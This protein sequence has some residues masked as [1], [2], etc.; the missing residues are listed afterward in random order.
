MAPS[1]GL[2]MT[3]S[4]AA[5]LVHHVVLPPKLP[6]EDDYNASHEHCLIDV[7]ICALQDVR[8]DVKGQDL[9]DLVT[10]AITA[11]MNLDDSRDKNGDVSELQVLTTLGKLAHATTDQILPLE[12]KAQNAGILASR[13]GDRVVFETFEL[14][15]TNKAAMGPTGRLIRSF[16]GSA[17]EIPVSVAKE[18][19]FRVSYAYTI[20]KMSTQN[21]REFRAQVRKNGKEVEEDRDTNDPAMVSEWLVN[22]LASM[23]CL[24][25]PVRIT[26]NMRE[27]VLWKDCRS[28]W[29]RSPLW[30]LI[31]VTLQLL[32]TRQG[33]TVRPLGGLYKAFVVQ[34]LSRILQSTKEHWKVL[35]SEILYVAYA[36][37]ARR[38]RKLE[39]L[40]QLDLLESR[41]AGHLQA[42]IVDAHNHIDEHWTSLAKRSDMNANTSSLHNL[43]PS[44]DLDLLLPELDAFLTGV[45]MRRRDR[46]LADF[47]PDGEYAAFPQDELPSNLRTSGQPNHL[48]LAALELWIEQHLELWLSV[49]LHENKTCGNIYALMQRYHS[50]ASTE[51]EGKPT[52]LSLMYLSLL[53]LWVASDSSACYIFPLLCQFDPELSSGELQCLVLPFRSQMQRLSNV[54]HY[55]QARRDQATKAN[56]SVLQQFGLASTFAVKYFDQS[57]ELQATL[58]EIKR[59]AAFKQKQKLEELANLKRRHKDLMDHYNSNTCQT[60]RVLVNRYH[61]YYEDKHSTS[62]TRCASKTAADDLDIMIYEWPLSSDEST[63][64][65]TV[66][67]LCIPQAFSDWRDASMYLI[68][69]VLGYATTNPTKPLVKYTLGQH[70]GLTHF[71]SS[72]YHGRRIVPLSSVKSHTS[73]HRKT[74]KVPNLT[75]DE[76][77]PANALMYM[78]F[79]TRL[80][81]YT[82]A[83][84]STESVAKKCMYRMPN[85][86]SKELEQFLYRP[87]SRPDG[88]TPNEV[89]AGL[90]DCPP[91]F[92][93]DEYKN[94][95]L[96]PFGRNIIYSNIL[97]QLATPSVD[98]AKAETHTLLLQAIEQ[99]GVS[100]HT[101]NRVSHGIL[102]DESFCCAMLEKL[103]VS[104]QRV[105]ENWESWRA[106]AIF[107]VL[108]RRIL[109]LTSSASIRHRSLIFLAQARQ[110]SMKWLGRLKTRANDSTED[111]QRSEL[112]SRATE[113]ALLC[114]QTFDVE[115]AYFD[116]IF[117]QPSAISILLQ[118]SITIQENCKAAQ[119]ESQP[120]YRAMLQSWK[121]LLCRA[122]TAL[123]QYILQGD[124]G[125]HTAVLENW[126]DFQ[127]N[128]GVH[129]EMLSEM[130]EHWISIRSRSLTV[131]FNL[132]TAELLVNGLPLARLPPK[133]MEHPLYVPLF[134]KSTLE[135]VPTDRPGMSFSA[136]SLYRDYKL[137]FGMND[138][139]MLIVAIDKNST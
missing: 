15:P 55:I 124:S 83:C 91:H 58:K 44:Q 131:Y 28:P 25:K 107:I 30:L 121:S 72:Q 41:W 47:R 19:D 89:V 69:S 32:F 71:L 129:W 9:R 104:L 52:S 78:Y 31:R 76:V 17:S 115:M 16:P 110:V 136:K 40:G 73:T 108:C 113:V 18:K 61:S 138:A 59:D 119:S 112:Y 90:S 100:N 120:V 51:Y 97:V 26:K 139:N 38:I 68:A 46:A 125:L 20:V 14:S 123:R 133:F 106:A 102:L 127:P 33:S 64:K 87:P 96:L 116:T 49:H 56:P 34:V 54:E 7:V 11:I 29:R 12:I 27:E 37:M 85:M 60:Q 48:Q 132:L 8:D 2:P 45:S 105:S 62:C 57:P 81:T 111:E 10:S 13:R 122:F 70:H 79:D 126:A 4:A 135:V 95:G 24:S 137:H 53:E 39:H 3:A 35:G 82:G 6:Q 93:I 98:F 86:R 99:C 114:S 67:E 77:C 21:A 22:N 117:Q 118:C 5:Y 92:S 50:M 109:S 84:V 130:H 75:D 74:K 42:A 65:A 134:G 66:F 103:E 63:A 36:K 23:G 1:D 43:R 80:G 101:P 94:F 128:P 88:K